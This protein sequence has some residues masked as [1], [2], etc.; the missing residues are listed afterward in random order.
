[1]SQSLPEFVHLHVHSEYSLLDGACKHDA[2]IERAK[3][4]GMP[5]LAVTDHGNLFG[6]VEFLQKAEKAGV[7]PIVGVEAY[8]TP[9]E[10][11][12]EDRATQQN[13]HLVLLAKDATGWRNLAR[14]VSTSFRDGFYYKPRID[15]KTLA[16]HAKGLVCLSACLKG[17]VVTHLTAGDYARARQVASWY[18]DTFPGD[19]YLEIQENG[20]DLQRR[21]NEGIE[22]LAKDLGLPLV[23]T[24]DVH[25]LTPEDKKAQD[26]LVCINT[27]KSFGDPNRLKMDAA[28]HFKGREEMAALFRGREAALAATLEIAAK[29]EVKAAA[30]KSNA[31]PRFDPP[32]GRDPNAY[33]RE[34]CEEGC[35]RR[36][37]DPPPAPVLA[38]LAEETAV[39]EKMGF[40]SYFLITWDFIKFARD[41][42]IPVG[43]GRGSAAG[44]IVAYALEI[45][46]IDPLRYDL[47]FERF[48]NKDRIS[49]P[50]NDIDFCQERREEVIDYVRRKYGKDNVCQII[51]FGTMAAKAVVRDVGRALDVPLKT[52]DQVAKKI[53]STL[54]IKLKEALEQEPDL[55][56]IY[57]E[58]PQIR[59]VF[60]VG[61]RLEGLARHAST[62][63]AGVVISDLPL[64]ERVPLYQD[65]K[66]GDVVSQFSMTVLEDVGL[67]KMD[68]LGLR[69]L[70][71]LEWAME[72]IERRTGTKLDRIAFLR[73]IPLDDP[74]VYAMLSRGD[75]RGVFQMESSGFTVLVK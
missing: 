2:L 40:V 3:A 13:H 17:E 45:T 52:V 29:C 42:G 70:T 73:D 7:K 56:K 48:L 49:M 35:R 39:I 36:Y 26:I 64:V 5:A 14:L 57:D 30:L 51:T 41:H 10:L 34:L 37:G 18:R 60:D 59:E 65:P 8:T 66:T 20:L 23:A 19:Y 21:A 31:L 46:D 32:D 47:L 16:A 58:D 63:A 28:L 9:G 68:F 4:E 22:R 74:K 75:T 24:G 71:V 44:S 53:P 38:R 67:L 1:M 62:H 27:G 54:H 43:P 50:D 72:N 6:A 69:T 15:K 25:Y 61:M 12:L 33:F 55:K 11:S